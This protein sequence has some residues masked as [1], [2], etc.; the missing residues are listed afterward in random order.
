MDDRVHIELSEPV[1]PQES[2]NRLRGLMP[3]EMDLKSA[4]IVDSNQLEH[5]AAIEWQIDL[6]QDDADRV[7][8]RIE[9]ILAGPCLMPRQTKK[10]K[11]YTADVRP[12]ILELSRQDN[13]V[14]VRS[15]LRRR[16][17]SDRGNF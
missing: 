8:Q 15:P 9:E 1:D 13:C 11:K 16:E 10:G 5:V 17:A 7:A 14:R 12:M 4:R 6:N 2:L 3:Q